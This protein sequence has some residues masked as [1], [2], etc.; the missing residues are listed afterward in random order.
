MDRHIAGIQ[1]GSSHQE[2]KQSEILCYR[3]FN[4]SLELK[5]GQPFQTQHLECLQINM[6]LFHSKILKYLWQM[7]SLEK[8]DSPSYALPE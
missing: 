4:L 6:M 2:W 5:R 1:T 3:Q 7:H 8:S